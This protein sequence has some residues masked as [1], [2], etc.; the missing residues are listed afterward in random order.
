MYCSGFVI[1]LYLSMFKNATVLHPSLLIIGTFLLEMLAS[2][3]VM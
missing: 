1:F 3:I 2:D